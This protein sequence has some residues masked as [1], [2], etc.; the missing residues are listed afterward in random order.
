MYS[1]WS[2]YQPSNHTSTPWQPP[3]A[4]PPPQHQPA[5]FSLL[6]GLNGFVGCERRA[7]VLLNNLEFVTDGTSAGKPTALHLTDTPGQNKREMRRPLCLMDIGSFGTAED[8]G[9]CGCVCSLTWG[10]T[11]AFCGRTT[12]CTA[13]TRNV[14]PTYQVLFCQNHHRPFGLIVTSARALLMMARP[15]SQGW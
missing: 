5:C 11:P 9:L 4:P 10:F 14:F 12:G 13:G 8:C 15:Q 7:A 1:G 3:T 6:A 2:I